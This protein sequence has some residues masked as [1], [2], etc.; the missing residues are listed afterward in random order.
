MLITSE[1]HLRVVLSEYADH[2]STY[3]L[4]RVLYQS[5]PVRGLHPPAPGANVR[6]LWRDRLGGLIRAYSRVFGTQGLE[7]G[8]SE[9]RRGRGKVRS[10][11]VPPSA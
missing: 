3:R 9:V 4:H 8:K 11:C 10:G 6:V 7:V 2:C 5:P 1:R